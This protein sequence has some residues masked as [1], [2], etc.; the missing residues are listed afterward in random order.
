MPKI[1]V[2]Y[3]K[4]HPFMFGTIFL[5]FGV[6]LW[7]L[8]NRGESSSASG[9][10]TTV[11]N[12]GPSDAQV[13]AGVAL[14]QAQIDSS[15]QMG[16]AHMASD[17]QIGLAQLEI[18]AHH[19]DNS[20]QRDLAAM[21][22]TAQMAEIQA[23]YNLGK[24]QLEASVASLGMQLSNNLAITQSNNGFML[25]YARQANDAATAQLM[26]GANL[27]ATLGAQA[28]DGYKYGID[29]SKYTATLATIPS[30]KKGDRDD[31]LNT[32]ITGHY[33]RI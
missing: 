2:A 1:N 33:Q 16:L 29:A 14:Q 28:L 8:L 30:L 15:T 22:L 25:D 7:M 26:I 12:P 19:D 20:A 17:T 10:G 31:A 23:S 13:M 9:G 4:Q 6:F 32:L 5:V 11:V 27:Q 18:A 24:G 3:V 21:A